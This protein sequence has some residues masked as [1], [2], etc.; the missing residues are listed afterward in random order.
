MKKPKF[1]SGAPETESQNSIN[2]LKAT[3]SSFRNWIPAGWWKSFD[4]LHNCTV[5]KRKLTFT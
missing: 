5:K 1:E 4:S 2:H 3:K